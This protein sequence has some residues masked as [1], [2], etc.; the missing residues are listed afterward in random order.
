MNWT[1]RTRDEMHKVAHAT[2]L[3]RTRDPHPTLIQRF[4][5]VVEVELR[6][7]TKYEFIEETWA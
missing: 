3:M 4:R 7:G 2:L 5:A 6:D 1:A